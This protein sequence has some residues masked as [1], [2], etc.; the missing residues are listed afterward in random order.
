MAEVYT[1]SGFGDPTPEQY[2]QLEHQNAQVI[3]KQAARSRIPPALLLQNALKALGD[4]HGDPSLSKLKQDGVIGP[5]TVKAVNYAFSNY[6]GTHAPLTL[7]AVR[8]NVGQLAQQITAYVEANGGS[9][10]PPWV[11]SRKKSFAPIPLPQMPAIPGISAGDNK[12][13]WWVVGGVSV[14]VVLT[15]VAKAIRRPPQPAKA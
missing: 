14:L 5:N 9:V 8:Q 11:G 3:Q 13:V 12:W 6:I 15:V 7:P 10:P 2:E 4:T 1:I